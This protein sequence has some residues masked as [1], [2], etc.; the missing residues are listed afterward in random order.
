MTVKT[1]DYDK[2]YPIRIADSWG[3]EI[4]VTLEGAKELLKDLKKVIKSLE[5]PIDKK[6]KVC[7]NN[8]TEKEMR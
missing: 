1:V 3:G 2:N 7:Y 8:S 5:K 6:P 4:C